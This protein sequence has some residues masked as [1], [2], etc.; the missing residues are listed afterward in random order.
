MLPE[1]IIMRTQQ[2]AK[3]FQEKGAVSS[4]KALTLQELNLEKK[5]QFFELLV[6]RK[7]IIEVG[8]KYYFDTERFDD[9]AL[10][11]VRDFI[12]GLFEEV[13]E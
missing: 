9:R 5:S 3:L 11:S 2:L 4:E 10:H 8:N 6:L 13:K 7:D 12:V 1:M